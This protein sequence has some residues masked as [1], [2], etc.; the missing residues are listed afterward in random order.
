MRQILS[1][2]LLATAFGL[3]TKA[4]AQQ[5]TSMGFLTFAGK[6][7]HPNAE[8]SWETIQELTVSHFNL[9]RS[10]DGIAYNTISRTTAIGDTSSNRTNKYRFTDANISALNDTGFYR[11]EC[12]GRDGF[13]Y[14][15]KVVAVSFAT[16]KKL[17]I[18]GSTKVQQ[19]LWLTVAATKPDRL[20]LVVTDQNGRIAKQQIIDCAKGTERKSM[21]VSALPAGMYIV[22]VLGGGMDMTARFVKH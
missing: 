1:V 4:D 8:L 13:A 3:F 12:V 11:L 19:T 10:I 20:S 6:A 14:Y 7:A 9:Q 5:T 16:S 15:S 22:S 17:V 21:D 2:L 18:M